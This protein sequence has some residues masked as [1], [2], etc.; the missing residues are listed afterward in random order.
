M[1]SDAEILLVA[2]VAPVLTENEHA[3]AAEFE[4]AGMVLGRR[5]LVALV[6][7]ALVVASGTHVRLNLGTLAVQDSIPCRAGM[8]ERLSGPANNLMALHALLGVLNCLSLIVTANTAFHPH[9]I[10]LE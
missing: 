6:A 10:N 2:S 5:N 7:V 1:A 4:H 8:G 9:E 3:M